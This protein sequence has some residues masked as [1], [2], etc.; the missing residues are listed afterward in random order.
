M[1]ARAFFISRRT[2]GHSTHMLACQCA[3]TQAHDLDRT[4]RRRRLVLFP[5]P[6]SSLTLVH[7]TIWFPSWESRSLEKLILHCYR[8]CIKSQFFLFSVLEY[9]ITIHFLPSDESSKAARIIRGIA[10]FTD[11]CVLPILLR[12]ELE[13][14]SFIREIPLRRSPIFCSAR[15]AQ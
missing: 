11:S 13:H 3:H 15:D 10:I 5:V 12:V 2:R 1:S 8:P 6:Q 7:L 14:T 9:H 4:C